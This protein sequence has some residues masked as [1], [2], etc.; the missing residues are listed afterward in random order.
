MSSLLVFQNGKSCTIL[1]K[2]PN[3]HSIAQ[4]K[5]AVNDGLR[6]INNVRIDG[7]YVVA[8]G[9]KIVYQL[10]FNIL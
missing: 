3:D 10:I 9:K 1:I 6:A 5:D 4:M 2:G 7:G 8:G